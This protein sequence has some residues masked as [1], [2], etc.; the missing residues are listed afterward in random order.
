MSLEKLH[1][2]YYNQVNVSQIWSS[3]VDV[4][5]KFGLSLLSGTGIFEKYKAVL[6]VSLENLNCPFITR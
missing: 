6:M 3:F 4:S 5:W 2:S 1:Y